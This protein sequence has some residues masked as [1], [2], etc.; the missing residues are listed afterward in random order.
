M[1]KQM[2]NIKKYFNLDD[3][4][5]YAVQKGQIERIEELLKHNADI[6]QQD[7]DGRTLLMDAIASEQL[8]MVRYLV[9][10][11]IEVNVHDRYDSALSLA[12]DHE[13]PEIVELLLQN[14]ASISYAEE[15]DEETM[16]SLAVEGGNL[17]IVKLLHEYG[18]DIHQLTYD[19]DTALEAALEQNHDDLA[20]WLIEQGL[21][22]N[23]TPKENGCLPLCEAID[24]PKLNLMR[25]FLKDD[26]AAKRLSPEHLGCFIH[27]F[28]HTD[29]LGLLQFLHEEGID[30]QPLINNKLL[31]ATIRDYEPDLDLIKFLIEQ[32]VDINSQDRHGMTALMVA[33]Y[34]DHVEVIQY[35]LD[36]GA[37]VDIK[38]ANGMMA[39]MYAIEECQLDSFELLQ[40][41]DSSSCDVKAT[42]DAA[43][44]KLQQQYSKNRETIMNNISFPITSHV[45]PKGRKC[46]ICGNSLSEGQVVLMIA[47]DSVDLSNHF[48]RENKHGGINFSQGTTDIQCCSKDCMKQLLLAFVDQI[49]D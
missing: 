37:K 13:K 44:K 32:G 39:K 2:D 7:V 28:W 26:I 20:I 3:A 4:L 23:E 34:H 33:A 38:A 8:E 16:F 30:I 27:H 47:D 10:N 9:Q 31:L 18:A 48:H 15:H 41:Y 12:I 40:Q 45:F 11:G 49:E 42:L 29:V 22:V 17:K 46:P 19:E 36:H 35:L 1:S 24:K 5:R 6:N 14:G 43:N 25:A 21:E